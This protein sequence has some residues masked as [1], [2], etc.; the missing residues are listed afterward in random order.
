[1][2]LLGWWKLGTLHDNLK[3]MNAGGKQA[4]N[5]WQWKVSQDRR[6]SKQA[7]HTQPQLQK[8]GL[9]LVIAPSSAGHGGGEDQARQELCRRSAC[10]RATV[11]QPPSFKAVK[12]CCRP[13]ETFWII[14]SIY[15]IDSGIWVPFKFAKSKIHSLKT[16]TWLPLN[17]GEAGYYKYWSFCH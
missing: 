16:T 2:F 4:P 8:V 17:S 11:V 14:S 12:P 1:M 9:V 13:G 5:S 10:Q 3:L 6:F 15:K 7:A